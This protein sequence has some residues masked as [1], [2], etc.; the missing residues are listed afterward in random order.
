MDVA[1]VPARVWACRVLHTPGHTEGSCSFYF[2][3][4]GLVISG[5]TLFHQSVGR[6]DLPTGSMGTLVRAIKERLFVLP[7]DTVVFPGHMDE[8]TIGFEKQHNPFL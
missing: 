4:G 1:E 6:T 2:E 3:E 8:T 5:D 7:D